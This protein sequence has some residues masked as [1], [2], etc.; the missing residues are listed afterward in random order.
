M[1]DDQK[2]ETI[3]YKDWRVSRTMIYM[4]SKNILFVHAFKKRAT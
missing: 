3:F 1:I 4:Q 2:G